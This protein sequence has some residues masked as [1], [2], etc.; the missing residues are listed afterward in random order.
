MHQLPS[1]HTERS[2][3]QKILRLEREIESCQGVLETM[4]S[5]RGCSGVMHVAVASKS[6][7]EESIG[8]MK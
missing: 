4:K 8:H 3:L 1:F 2:A 6:S 5:K 7:E